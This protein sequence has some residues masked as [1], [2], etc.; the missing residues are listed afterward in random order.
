MIRFTFL[1][2]RKKAVASQG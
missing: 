2:Y 1:S